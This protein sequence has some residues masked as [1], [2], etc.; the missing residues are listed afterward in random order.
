MRKG[1]RLACE[2]EL[3]AVAEFSKRAGDLR[4][5]LVFC[6]KQ[7]AAGQRE[8]AGLHVHGITLLLRIAT[9]T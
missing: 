6:E 5:G 2:R 3:R 4:S 7:R 1:L 9:I 8:I